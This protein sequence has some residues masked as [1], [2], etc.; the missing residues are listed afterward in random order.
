M[1]KR[2]IVIVLVAVAILAVGKLVS[3][4]VGT[5]KEKPAKKAKV[6]ETIV[7]A[8]TV[9]NRSIPILVS[10][11]GVLKAVKRM[12]MFSEVQG[13]MEADN[14]RFKAGN[15]F[16]K[17]ELLVRIRSNDQQAQLSSQRSAFESALAA[18]MPDLK[19]DYP[20]EF[21]KWESYLVDFSTSNSVNQL[22]TVS[23]A[24][25]KSFLVGRGIYRDY[26][27]LKNIEIINSKYA[28]RAPYSGVLTAANVDPGTIIRQGQ[29]LGTFIQP[30][31]YEMET[32]IDAVAAERLQ[33]GQ[34]VQLSMQGDASKN[35]TGKIARLVNA[36][37]PTTQMSS[38]YVTVSGDDLKE[39]MFLQ[40]QVQANEIVNAV[41]INRSA[42]VDNNQVYVV[43]GDSLV[44][45]KIV[46]EYL[47]ENTAVISGLRT[48]EQLLTK[49][50]PAAY[51]GLKV[52]IYKENK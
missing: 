45:K 46:T 49:V 32:A 10:S 37:D 4:K 15:S 2:Q 51:P 52:S 19:V 38:F 14:G 24:Q 23:S 5:P 47:G 36:I 11:T 28:I 42:L 26:H 17:G 33:V 18:V 9:N 13:R 34:A 20:N 41:E 3:D 39:G 30:K 35:W 48:G 21:G 29:A 31:H 1:K 16:Q 6:N 25:L 27:S 12:E 40:A 43:E 50:P 44:L 8:E 22:P 7:F